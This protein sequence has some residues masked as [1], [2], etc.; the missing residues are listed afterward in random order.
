MKPLKVFG[1][2]VLKCKIGKTFLQQSHK[3]I[4][5]L[6]FFFLACQALMPSTTTKANCLIARITVKN[7]PWLS[8]LCSWRRQNLTLVLTHHTSLIKIKYRRYFRTMASVL[9]KCFTIVFLS[10]QPKE[11][12]KIESFQDFTYRL[13]ARITHG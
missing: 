4:L 3:S 9:R 5:L 2:L 10:L 13:K 1:V 12:C 7:R 8:I 6:F 11:I